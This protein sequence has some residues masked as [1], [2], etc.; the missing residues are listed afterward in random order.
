MAS[1]IAID[2]GGTGIKAGHFDA[3][4]RELAV[5]SRPTPRPG[6]PEAIFASFKE[7]VATLDPQKRAS[8]IGVGVPGLVDTT[9]RLVY[10]TC[11]LDGW[12]D[13]PLAEQLEQATGLPTVLGNDAN[14]AALGEVWLGSASQYGSA[15]LLTL[16]TGVGGGII[17]QGTVFTG[18]RGLAGEIGHMVFDR[19]GPACVCGSKGCLEQYISAPAIQRRFGT[20]PEVLGKLAESGDQEALA[21]WQEVGKDLGFA[22][23]SLLNLLDSEVAIV[24]GGVSAS[25]R[26]MFPAALEEMARYPTSVRP[27]FQLLQASLGNDAGRIGAARL[28]LSTLVS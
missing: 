25:C 14:L 7:I 12:H 26:F 2:L 9:G 1:V 13:V 18:S 3:E 19:S 24:G 6:T 4:G 23:V 8:A 11:N 27:G 22:L 21:C 28:A 5:I 16:G 20:D 17:H 10:A 15:I